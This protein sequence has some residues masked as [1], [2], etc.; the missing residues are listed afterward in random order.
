MILKSS[1]R[2]TIDNIS[3]EQLDLAVS[4]PQSCSLCKQFHL[5]A[6]PAET[7]E[8]TNKQTTMQALNRGKSKQSH[9]VKMHVCLL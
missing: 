2:N 9:N 4:P 8:Q 3:Q 1:T 6:P 7:N 5:A